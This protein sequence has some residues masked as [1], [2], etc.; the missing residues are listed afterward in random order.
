MAARPPRPP[1][2]ASRA[3]C[4][5]CRVPLLSPTPLLCSRVVTWSGFFD[6]EPQNDPIDPRFNA[7]QMLAIVVEE[8]MSKEREKAI[9]QVQSETRHD[10]HLPQTQERG[11]RKRKH[12]LG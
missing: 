11:A 1:R 10:C 7:E 3:K 8:H 9:N 12:R 5:L 2:T 6:D 4:Q